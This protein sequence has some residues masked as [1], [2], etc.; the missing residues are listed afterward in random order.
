MP[1]GVKNLFKQRY[2]TII[3]K[4][5]CESHATVPAGDDSDVDGTQHQ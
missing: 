2:I 4:F 5:G 1:G 3:L